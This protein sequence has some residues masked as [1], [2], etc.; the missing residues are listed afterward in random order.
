MTFLKNRLI[1]FVFLVKSNHKQKK[2]VAPLAKQSLS[3]SVYEEL[4]SRIVKCQYPP[5]SLLSEEQLVRELNASRTPI[6]SALI[7]LQQENLVQTLP[8]KGI[9]VTEITPNSIRDLFNL[10]ELLELYAISNF[11]QNFEKDR[12]LKY[13]TDF[14][15]DVTQRAMADIFDADV[16]FHIE[17]VNLTGNE[18]LASYYRSMQYHLTRLTQ[19]CAL[20]AEGRLPKSNDEHRD[21]ILALMKDDIE[22]AYSALKDHLKS[23]REAAYRSILEN[24]APFYQVPE[25]P[26]KS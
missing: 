18:L 16:L 20:N 8:K 6:R 15:A 24:P 7:R 23:A 14:P 2:G 11:G 10:R 1:Y 9:L 26:E 21:I 22:T 25:S 19:I 5:G 4:L 12:L 3:E 17:I 13:L